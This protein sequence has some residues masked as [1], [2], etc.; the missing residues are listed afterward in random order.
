MFNSNHAVMETVKFTFPSGKVGHEILYYTGVDWPDER[1]EA[2]Q[3]LIKLLEGKAG[4]RVTIPRDLIPHL[5]HEVDNALDIK[6]DHVIDDQM[7]Q[8][9]KDLA[10]QRGSYWDPDVEWL[11]KDHRR[12]EQ[13]YRKLKSL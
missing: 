9:E 7:I 13:F 3:R 10:K 5:I 1:P 11:E 2:A 4:K 12:L 6:Q 8:W